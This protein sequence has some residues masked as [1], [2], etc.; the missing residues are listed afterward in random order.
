M[1]IVT[2]SAV[3]VLAVLAGL[4]VVKT[5]ADADAIPAVRPAPVAAT[6]AAPLPMF[7]VI[8]D[9]FAAGFTHQLEESSTLGD[10]VAAGVTTAA[11]YLSGA[12]STYDA[13]A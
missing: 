7:G 3:V 2:V 5:R 6:A 1:R 9:S 11:A 4:L 13:A 10:A 12:L 8:G